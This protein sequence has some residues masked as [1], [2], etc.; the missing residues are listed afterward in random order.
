MRNIVL[1]FFLLLIIKTANGQSIKGNIKNTEG[2]AV[3]YATVYIQELKQGTVTNTKGDYE[4]KLAPGKYTVV[5]QSLGYAPDIK[6]ITLGVNQLTI[7]V[8]LQVQFYEIP[9]VRITASGEDPA[10]GIMRKVIGL[11]PYY[12]NQVDSYKAT[13]YL[14]GNLHLKKIPKIIQRRMK[15]EARSEST[16]ESVSSTTMKAGDTYMMESVNEIEFKAP[17]RYVQRVI[18]SRSTFPDQRSDISPMDFIQASFYEPVLNDMF[19]S[20]LSPDAFFHYR[21]RYDG[22][23]LQ[24]NNVINKIEVIPKRKSQQLFEGVIYII[25]DLWCL[26]SIDL[27]NDNIAGTLRVQQVFVPVVEDTWMPVSQKFEINISIVG[28]K[29]D[30][31]YGSSVKY[32]DVK[33]NARLK[34]PAESS[35]TS[36]RAAKIRSQYTDTVSKTQQQINKI[37]SKEDLNNRDMAKLS[38]LIQKQ[39]V[40]NRPDSISK[41]LE[42]KD[43][44]TYIIEKDAN[45]K[46]SAYWSD[47]RPIPLSPDETR[48][49]RLA[50]SIKASLKPSA[51]KNDTAKRTPAE[52]KNTFIKGAKNIFFGHTWSDTTGFSFFSKGLIKFSNISFNTVDGFTYGLNFRL[53]KRW[54]DGPSFSIYPEA[55]YAFAREK[56]MWRLNSQFSFR[57][58]GSFYIRTGSFSRD[59][60]NSGGIDP[61]L[62]SVTSLFLEKNY[63]KLYETTFLTGGFRREVDN[64]LTLEV[65]GTYEKRSVLDN[66][67]S[68]SFINTSGQYTPNK[69]VNSYL[70]LPSDPLR[71]ISDQNHG[72]INIS[73]SWTPRQ[74]YSLRNGIKIPR[75]SDYPT[76][77]LKYEHGVSA[78]SDNTADPV[79]YVNLRF[80]ANKRNSI[81]AFG[82][83]RWR[84]RAG[85]MLNSDKVSFYDFNHFNSQ[86][87]EVLLSDFED[88]F[89]LPKYYSLSTPEYFTELHL[90]YTT[91]YLFLKLLR[92]LSNTLMRENLSFSYLWSRYRSVYSEI[93][94]SISEVLFLGEIGVYAGFDNLTFNSVGFRTVLRFN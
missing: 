42:I 57:K 40:E 83:F 15:I 20:P 4:L 31:G 29:A 50:D 89:R 34:R 2:E 45:R 78:R 37:L 61:F 53:G 22:L 32:S 39:A 47:I 24:G 9:E 87:L 55:R 25:E 82:E 77:S 27:S 51:L 70:A 49:I 28:V 91:P 46:D 79:N 41:S 21:F 26:H 23:S 80:E 60:N 94:Y 85:G 69:P 7:N 52:N 74:K 14:K 67:T 71:D 62:N 64:G 11:A 36:N 81:G 63:L 38:S 76:F 56:V 1:I 8:V 30:A 68:Y 75:G 65:L 17:D 43:K 48:S 44:T 5:Y 66:N 92:V 58:T 13:V 33:V 88:A 10:Y 54:K 3:A 86:P 35:F 90:K 84:F 72:E 12:L 93:G 16:G 59:F 73:L 19:I 6:N 18:S